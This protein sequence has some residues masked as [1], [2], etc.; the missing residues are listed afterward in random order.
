MIRINLLKPEK[1][2]SAVFERTEREKT[3]ATLPLFFFSVVVIAIVL[4]FFQ[5]NSF[6]RQ[7]NFLQ[8]AQEEKNSLKEVETTLDQV[9][10]QIATIIKKI[11][12]INQ[13]K[14]NQDTAVR[15]M[16]ELSKNLPS[17]ISLIETNFDGKVV[18][19]KGKALTNKLIADYLYNLDKTTYFRNVNLVSSIQRVMQDSRFYEFL[20]N[21]TYV[22]PLKPK[23]EPPEKKETKKVKT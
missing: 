15:I 2:E 13:L 21:A 20:M 11:D 10:K 14:L 12:L 16:D 8:V 22:P 6:K 3:P 23:P 1:K 7:N 9:E 4:L 5:K 19:I 18:R 17:W